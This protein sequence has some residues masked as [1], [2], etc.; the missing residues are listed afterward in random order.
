ML[1]D[2]TLWIHNVHSISR[3]LFY[4]FFYFDGFTYLLQN[5]KLLAKY[6]INSSLENTNWTSSKLAAQVETSDQ[7]RSLTIFKIKTSMDKTFG[8]AWHVS[9]VIKNLFV[10]G[11]IEGHHRR[12]LL[13][14][15]RAWSQVYD[16]PVLWQP[17]HPPLEVWECSG[18]R[19][20]IS[21]G[22]GGR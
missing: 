1:Y 4:F 19:N 12:A 2:H 6:I 22:G 3:G 20:K 8:A 11:F 13:L 9:L 21:H 10:E 7:I 16:V 17:G 15:C 18:Q 5:E 14:C